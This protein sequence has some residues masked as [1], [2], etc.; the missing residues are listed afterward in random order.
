VPSLVEKLNKDIPFFSGKVFYTIFS[1]GILLQPL[2]VW[3]Q[4]IKAWTTENIGGISL[5]TFSIMLILQLIG[6]GYGIMVKE[7]VVFCAMSISILGS[8]TI[9]MAILMRS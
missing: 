1:F 6:T 5:T 9:I 2:A 4:A 3:S 8:L 7:P